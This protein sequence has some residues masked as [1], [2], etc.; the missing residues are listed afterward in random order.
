MKEIEIINGHPSKHEEPF[1]LIGFKL[2]PDSE[3]PEI[4][5][6]VFGEK[7]RPLIKNEQII[8]FPTPEAACRALEFCGTETLTSIDFIADDIELIVDIAETLYLISSE[9]IDLNNTILNTINLLDDIIIALEIHRPQFY[10]NNLYKF[11]DH[12]TFNRSIT[13]FLETEQITRA[14]IINS[15]LWCIGAITV[16]SIILD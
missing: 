12:L 1:Y 15:L 13:P 16:Q 11:A 6:L 14:S 10:K 9:E 8:F 2:N 5:T 4:Y 7:N 3:K